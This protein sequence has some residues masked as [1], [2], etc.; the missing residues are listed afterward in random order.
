[1]DELGLVEERRRKY[2]AAEMRHR[3]VFKSVLR[4]WGEAI[5]YLEK[6]EQ[7]WVYSSVL[8]GES[9]AAKVSHQ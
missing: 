8:A 3:Q 5:R 4:Y 6:P 1:M 7:P 9:A 2:D